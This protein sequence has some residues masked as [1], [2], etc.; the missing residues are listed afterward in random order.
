MRGGLV[1][2]FAA[3]GIERSAR[4]AAISS[5]WQLPTTLA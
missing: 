4:I 1:V 2:E 3:A 5:W